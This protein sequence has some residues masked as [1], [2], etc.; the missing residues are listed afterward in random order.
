MALLGQIGSIYDV[1]F[2]SEQRGLF[3]SKLQRNEGFWDIMHRFATYLEVVFLS[4][5]EQGTSES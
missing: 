1:I 3:L 4:A 5:P 2:I